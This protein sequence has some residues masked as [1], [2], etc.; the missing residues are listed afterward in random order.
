MALN[1]NGEFVLPADRAT[2]WA[3][4]NDPDVLRTCIPGCEEF[5]PTGDN[6]YHAIAKIKIGPV[7]ARFKGTVQLSEIDAPHSYRISGQMADRHA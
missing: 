4:L 6:A 7:G 2:V 1:M 5:T 3:K